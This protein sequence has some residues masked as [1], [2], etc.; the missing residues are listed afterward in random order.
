M[1]TPLKQKIIA[2]FMNN[3]EIGIAHFFVSFKD[4][5]RQAVMV[6]YIIKDSKIIRSE[7][8]VRSIP[9]YLAN[10]KNETPTK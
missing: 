8:G 10:L 1:M 2:L 9:K 4:D 7:T 3:D 6:I 5:P